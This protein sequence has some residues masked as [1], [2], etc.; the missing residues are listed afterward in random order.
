[1]GVVRNDFLIKIEKWNRF[2]I[3]PKIDKTKHPTVLL[4]SEI[5]STQWSGSL[6]INEYKKGGFSRRFHNST[7]LSRMRSIGVLLCILLSIGFCSGFTMVTIANVLFYC[8]KNKPWGIKMKIDFKHPELGMATCHFGAF[9]GSDET[10]KDNCTGSAQAS[11][12]YVYGKHTCTPDGRSKNFAFPDEDNHE[13]WV[14]FGAYNLVTDDHEAAYQACAATNCRLPKLPNLP[15]FRCRFSVAEIGNKKKPAAYE[16]L[17]SSHLKE[18]CKSDDCEELVEG[19]NNACNSKLSEVHN[20]GCKN[21][22]KKALEEYCDASDNNKKKSICTSYLI[23]IIIGASV[24]ALVLLGV[25]IFVFWKCRKMRK[26]KKVGQASATT[27]IKTNGV[28]TEKGTTTGQKNST[29]TGR[30]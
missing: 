25:L 17:F 28:S 8:N 23:Y 18:E 30:Y 2:E 11:F 29:A 5:Q 21:G 12:W 16:K 1:M 24:G 26:N 19:F 9:K 10:F 20:K 6:E 15:N 13:K 14:G 3:I 27:G 22:L 4:I 7:T